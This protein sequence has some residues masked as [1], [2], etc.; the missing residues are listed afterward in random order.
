MATTDGD[1]GHR[2]GAAG[3]ATSPVS[4]RHPASRPAVF[5]PPMPVGGVYGSREGLA[6]GSPNPLIPSLSVDWH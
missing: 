2:D 3:S 6:T 1:P 4:V 5:R